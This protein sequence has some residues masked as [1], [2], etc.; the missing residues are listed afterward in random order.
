MISAARVREDGAL[1]GR[2]EPCTA[3]ARHVSSPP[4]VLRGPTDTLSTHGSAAR[5]GDFGAVKVLRHV[6]RVDF[7]DRHKPK[8]TE[9]LA[10]HESGHPTLSP[11]SSS[12]STDV[13]SRPCDEA[14]VPS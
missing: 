5:C 3:E 14:S 8:C 12:W 1:G 10:T 2:E 7:E 6:E 11:Q 9:S 13:A 4:I